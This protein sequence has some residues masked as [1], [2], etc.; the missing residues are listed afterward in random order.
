MNA[1]RETPSEGK[2]R[3]AETVRE[4]S[5]NAKRKGV[6]KTTTDIALAPVKAAGNAVKSTAGF[7]WRHKGKLIIGG[8]IAAYVAPA[9]FLRLWGRKEAAAM[10]PGM[11]WTH[12]WVDSMRPTS[13]GL[14][15]GSGLPIRG[16]YD[17]PRRMM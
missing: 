14:A 8:L 5:V 16:G 7:L 10:G 6:F 11:D 17:R 13:P 9:Y 3:A 12:R 1:P 2:N 4:N 15:P